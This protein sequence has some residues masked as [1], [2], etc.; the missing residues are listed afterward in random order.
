MRA[1]DSAHASRRPREADDDATNRE[2]QMVE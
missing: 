1:F 2:T